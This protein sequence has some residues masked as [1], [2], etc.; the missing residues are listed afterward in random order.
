MLQKAR[1]LIEF[2]ILICL[3]SILYKIGNSEPAHISYEAGFEEVKDLKQNI[4]ESF[5]IENADDHTTYSYIPAYSHTYS[6]EGTP[7]EMAVTLSL[8]NVD[9]KNPLR[10]HQVLYYNTKGDLIRKYLKDGYTLKPLETKEI[11]IKKNDL[12]GGSGANFIVIFNSNS[13]HPIFEAVM[14]SETDGKSYIFSSRGTFYHPEN[15]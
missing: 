13:L 15:K 6:S 3:L 2:L 11:F 8:R 5:G 10:I 9:M 7:L 14:A 4:Q 1:F 12:E